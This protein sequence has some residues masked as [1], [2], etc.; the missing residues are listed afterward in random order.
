MKNCYWI[1]HRWSKWQEEDLRST[2][3]DKKLLGKYIKRTC[4][5]C[6]LVQFKCIW[7]NDV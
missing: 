6:G 4:E 2:K 3:E 7:M 5:K 1:F